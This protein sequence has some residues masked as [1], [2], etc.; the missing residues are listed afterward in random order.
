MIGV[1]LLTTSLIS[2]IDVS[3][4]HGFAAEDEAHSVR[5]AGLPGQCH[6]PH[7]RRLYGIFSGLRVIEITDEQKAQIYGIRDSFRD[8]FEAVRINSQAVR[9][10]VLTKSLANGP[11]NELC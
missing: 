6:N 7:H 2:I 9:Q 3:P 8:P 4:R 5:R 11:L 10:E 1:A